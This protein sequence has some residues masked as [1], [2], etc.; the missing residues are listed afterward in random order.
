[1]MD[2]H[3]SLQPMAAR[4]PV[5][6]R[7]DDIISGRTMIR[8]GTHSRR[9]RTLMMAA[10]S[11]TI[12]VGAGTLIAL[13]HTDPTDTT[14]TNA[15]ASTAVPVGVPEPLFV[16]PI[17]LAGGLTGG[18]I[19]VGHVSADGPIS[20]LGVRDGAGYR[21]LFTIAVYDHPVDRETG[22]VQP[23]VEWTPISLATGP[24][25]IL[26]GGGPTMTIIQQRGTHW[27]RVDAGPGEAVRAMEAAIVTDDGSLALSADDLT[28]LTTQTVEPTPL[29]TAQLKTATNIYVET[30]TA[31]SPF[32]VNI[33]G[34]DQLA[35]P[36]AVRGHAGWQFTNTMPDGTTTQML[37]WM[38]TPDRVVIVY[39]DSSIDR[40]LAVAENLIV[41]D[42]ATWD[43]NVTTAVE[44]EVEVGAEGRT[45]G[46]EP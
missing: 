24:A 34:S 15:P 26:D 1:M 27:V 3:D 5:E 21:D 33:N 32:A 19:A 35:T 17:D 18:A 46:T 22:I 40:L 30:A 4:V 9:P 10:A 7:L 37:S 12:A 13:R 42:Y 31:V 41:V 38:E 44:V 28:I 43:E 11:L 6:D 14:P 2:L 36:I 25:Q 23:G 39:G 29:V 45:T 20:L 8:D 16:L